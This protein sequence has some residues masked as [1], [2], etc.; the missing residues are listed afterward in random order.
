MVPLFFIL[1]TLI[2][3]PSRQTR[4]LTQKV[5]SVQKTENLVDDLLLAPFSKNNSSFIQQ[6]TLQNILNAIKSD[7][8]K[9]GLTDS[10]KIIRSKI[11][12]INGV[13][14][15]LKHAMY[16]AVLYYKVYQP[17]KKVR[18]LH[19]KD[20]DQE[21]LKYDKDIFQIIVWLNS[22][23]TQEMEKVTS[24]YLTDS[25]MNNLKKEDVNPDDSVEY[26]EYELCDLFAKYYF[27]RIFKQKK[28]ELIPH[29][30]SLL[31][32]YTFLQTSLKEHFEDAVIFKSYDST[33]SIEQYENILNY[34]AKHLSDTYPYVTYYVT[35]HE[36]KFFTIYKIIEYCL[37]SY[38]ED[39]WVRVKPHFNVLDITEE[40][41]IDLYNT[42]VTTENNV[43]VNVIEHLGYN[44][45]VLDH[46]DKL[47]YYYTKTPTMG[48]YKRFAFIVILFGIYHESKGYQGCTL[49]NIRNYIDI[50]NHKS[51]H[52]RTFIKNVCKKYQYVILNS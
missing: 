43:A 15:N 22:K 4:H 34:M 35:E 32:E 37:A 6:F 14:R 33:E 51:E 49:E 39:D 11:L 16:M 10:L 3:T 27:D 9:L 26:E 41:A 45:K 38:K 47:S 50:L 30:H 36:N 31:E 23:Y 1:S 12:G 21:T 42:A 2:L 46:C 18:G 29:F 48:L 20:R 19:F 17:K 25:E 13:E 28:N 5:I 44:K 52:I 40:Q 24:K 8:K 7:A